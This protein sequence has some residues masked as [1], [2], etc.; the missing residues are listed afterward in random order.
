M[1][2]TNA[3]FAPDSPAAWRRAGL[4]L[5]IS[6]IGNVGMWSVVV[7]LPA[8]QAAFHATRTEASG[9][10]T[11]AMLGF[12]VGGVVTGRLADRSGI[13]P[14]IALA[15]LAL[16]VGYVGAGLSPSLWWFV[17]AHFAIGFG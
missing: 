15:I 10:F 13:L 1:T 14:A 17:V 16:L 7:A 2:G 8:V 3:S 6:A 11:M 5:T 4:A 12:G 9:A